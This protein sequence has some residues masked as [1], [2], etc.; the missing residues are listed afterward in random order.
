MPVLQ[1]RL[2]CPPETRL[3]FAGVLA[4]FCHA[5][6]REA[7]F[8][9]DKTFLR[10]PNTTPKS[11]SLGLLPLP[12]KIHAVQGCPAHLIN[13]LSFSIPQ[14]CRSHAVIPHGTRFP[15]PRGTMPSWGSTMGRAVCLGLQDWTVVPGLP[16][17]ARRLLPKIPYPAQSHPKESVA[18]TPCLGGSMA[19][20]RQTW[21]CSAA[22]QDSRGT[23]ELWVSYMSLG[24]SLQL[25]AAEDKAGRLLGSQDH[26]GW[27]NTSKIIKFHH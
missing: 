23:A 14:K 2:L 10:N 3:G 24:T 18:N 8:R 7:L 1:D 19:E 21:A 4:P 5:S 15:P 26:L 25:R 6:L 13:V 16:I 22:R 27:K 20:T 11:I 17:P 12:G 9:R